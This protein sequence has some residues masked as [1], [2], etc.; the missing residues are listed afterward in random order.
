MSEML[1]SEVTD[2]VAVLTIDRPEALN[3]MNAAL[4]QALDAALA[5]LETGEVR[6]AIL[7][8]TGKAFVAGADIAAMAEM[9]VADAQA[10]SRFGHRVARRLEEAPF[11]TLAAVNGFA[12]GGGCELALACDFIYASEKAKLGLPEVG[13]GVV[14]GWGGTQRLPR[15]V[16]VGHA[17]ELVFS[18]RVID[19]AEAL[20]IGLVNAVFAPDALLD[21]AQAT[22]REVAAK[23]PCAVRA[24]K[25][26]MLEGPEQSLTEANAAEVRAFGKLFGTADQREGMQ[27]FLG[28]RAPAFEGR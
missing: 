4:L 21:A 10:F 3:A 5:T 23:G 26:L 13:L 7:T 6:A 24:A 1:R 20:R 12:L 14:P 16:G 18:G 9:S 19:A 11:P 17:R 25:R 2:G 15:R 28:K 22:A 27:A 8:G